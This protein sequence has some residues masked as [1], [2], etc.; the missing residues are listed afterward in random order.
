MK[1]SI[2]QFFGLVDYGHIQCSKKK[3]QES[4]ISDLESLHKNTEAH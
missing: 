1:E 3:N 2:L 4:D